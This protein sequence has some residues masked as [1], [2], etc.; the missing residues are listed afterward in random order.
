MSG[1]KSPLIKAR[2]L[3]GGSHLPGPPTP[4]PPSPTTVVMASGRERNALKSLSFLPR[5][6][7]S[8]DVRPQFSPAGERE[9][10]KGGGFQRL[11]EQCVCV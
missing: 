3:G 5:R 9:G 1:N 7:L 11:E 6:R 4:S 10:A 2:D 8:G